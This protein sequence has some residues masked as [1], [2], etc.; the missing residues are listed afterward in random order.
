M[1]SQTINLNLI[2]GSIEPVINVSQY[3]KGQ[4]WNFNI[5]SGS[6][7]FTIPTGS[8]I[9][10]QGTKPDKTGFQYGCTFSGNVVTAI[11]QQQMTI[12]SGKV[13]AEI[14]ITKDDELIGSLNFNIMV[15]KAALADDTAI[16]E[17]DLP[18]I[19]EAVEALSHIDETLETMKGY[20]EDS[21]AYANGKRNGSDVG[22][23][24]PAYH[25][26]S[27][28][29]AGQA[30]SSASSASGSATSAGTNALISEGYAV[31]KQNGSAV[32]S[33]SPYYQNNAEYYKGQAA[34]S[35]TNAG[36]SAAAA[37]GS[38]TTASN[39][40]LVAEGYADGKQNGT[41]VASGS[42]Y[43]H[44]N[45]KYYSEQAAASAQSAAQSAASFT[46]DSALSTSSTNPVQN[47]VITT[48]LNNVK[49]ALSDEV[50]TRAKLGAHNLGK[51]YK[52]G[53]A[54]AGITIKDAPDGGNYVNNTSTGSGGRL[55]LKSDNFVLKAG[56]YSIVGESNDHSKY[57]S[58][59][60]QKTSDS[61]VLGS[62]LISNG[63]VDKSQATFTLAE[64][65]ECY[66]GFNTS[67]GVAYGT[68]TF[69][70]Y[71]MVKLAD[72]K[73]D[74]FYP[75]AMTNKELTDN[76][77]DASEIA[78]IENGTTA[79]TA[80]EQGAYFIHNGK[81]CK[82][83]TAIASGASFTLNTNYEVT[84]VAAELIALNA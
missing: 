33:G 15:E 56:T 17:T 8:S 5:Y 59:V 45:S 13:P 64:D 22:S 42:P 26:N 3:D 76:K 34:N 18:L 2:P 23:S 7:P 81:F 12:L 72:D 74:T 37:S 57:S 9:T 83:K 39:R 61:S 38:A 10:I 47:K 6:Q 78:P 67:T 80:Y 44:N 19:E 1:T 77:I 55:V 30:S 36:N 82:A 66:F 65:T 4:T 50:V 20:K 11:E 51:K 31:G 40:A 79:S 28:Y 54:S 32:G 16:S 70:I 27:R 68:N 29:Y 35:A 25:N 49:Q 24:D 62:Y 48:D 63:A 53:V 43:Y 14:V 73:D 84:T 46:V 58:V 21:E 71:P 69:I 60:L 41:D 52:D 75:Y